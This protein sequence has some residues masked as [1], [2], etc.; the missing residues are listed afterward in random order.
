M[1]THLFESFSQMIGEMPAKGIITAV[2]LEHRMLTDD[3]ARKRTLPYEEAHSVLS[4][5][6]FLEAAKTGGQIPHTVLPA[7]DTEFY[8]KTTERLVAA[9]ELPLDANERF[10][11]TFS[12]ARLKLLSPA[13]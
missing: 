5:C 1:S 8:R 13:V 11:A 12:V 3:L 7:V 6:R 9:G 10:D 4:F 2:E